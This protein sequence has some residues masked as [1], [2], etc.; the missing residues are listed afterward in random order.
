[1]LHQLINASSSVDSET[2]NDE[3]DNAPHSRSVWTHVTAGHGYDSD[4][5]PTPTFAAAHQHPASSIH[6]RLNTSTSSM[7]SSFDRRRSLPARTSMTSLVSV[8][9][10]RLILIA[11]NSTTG[12]RPS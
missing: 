11:S 3:D 4:N 9:T 1:E 12:E 2:E 10:I 6:D 8:R 7:A 5:I